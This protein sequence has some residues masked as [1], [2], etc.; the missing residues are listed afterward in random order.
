MGIQRRYDLA[1]LFDD[2]ASPDPYHQLQ[3]ETSLLV[4][5]CL[6]RHHAGNRFV[7]RPQ[8]YPDF[9]CSGLTLSR[10]HPRW[11]LTGELRQR[12]LPTSFAQDSSTTSHLALVTVLDWL[13]RHRRINHFTQS[14]FKS[15][16][17][18]NVKHY[19]HRFDRLLNRVV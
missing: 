19:C 15:P 16:K 2:Q 8:L 10:R 5:L 6:I 12:F 13:C 17:L 14:T 11:C 4:S 18:G 1:L 9:Q 7:L 3:N